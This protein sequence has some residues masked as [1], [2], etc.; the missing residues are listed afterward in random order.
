[1]M[2]ARVGAAALLSVCALGF[3]RDAGAQQR[4]RASGSGYSARIDTSFAFDK[5]GSLTLNATNGD[6][7]VTGWSRDVVHVRA[8]SDDDNIRLEASSSRALLEVAGSRRGSD[9]RFE[10]SV[11]FGVR[12]M[13]H[14]QSGDI[15]IRATR[16][17]VEA[18]AQNGDIRVDD[19]TTRLD[20][21]TLS[22]EITAG[23]IT[24]DIAVSTMS[25]EVHLTDVRGNVDVGTV[26]GDIDLRGVTAKIV[27]AKTTSGEV[28][29]DGTIDPAGRYELSTHS[30]DIGLHIPREANA[31]LTVS[32]WSGSIDSQFPITLKPG[33][34]DIGVAKS[35][36]YTFEIGG[37]AARITAET[38]SGDINI[39]SNGRGAPERR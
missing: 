20:I 24:G 15:T 6:I 3:A 22:G 21:S 5:S 12:V 32:T 38:F 26:S 2:R 33:E 28:T 9:T 8:V 13:A 23:T 17:Q 18:H 11:P 14:S 29:Y 19:V 1:M 35:K 27:R 10:V 30:G 37:G 39:S 25:G 31:Q 4:R 34:H 7:I 16:G 36:R